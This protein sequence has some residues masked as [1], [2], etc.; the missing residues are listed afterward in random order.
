MDIK[1]LCT[2]WGYKHLPADEFL[3][4]VKSA[5][6]DGV[7]TWMPENKT[8]RK[9]FIQLIEQLDLSI[10]SH[11]HQATGNNIQAFCKSFEYYLNVALECEPLL[12]NSHSGRDFFTIDEQLAVIDV[13]ENFSAKNNITVAHETHRGRIGFCPGNAAQLF[14]LRP[15]MKITADLS[16]WVCVTESYLENFEKIVDEAINR[17]MHVH[18]RVGFIE[19]PQVPDPRLPQWQEALNH[20][21][22]WWQ[23]IIENKKANNEALIT[24][25][26]EFG[27]P[28]YMWTGLADNEPLA[29]QWDINLHIKELIK[30]I[31]EEGAANKVI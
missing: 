30:T 8:E 21:K 6:Y 7:D 2:Q 22:K 31:F 23:N 20:F 29:N 9:N 1:I 12:I 5:G 3:E 13:A 19:G 18:A 15:S 17:T 14:K 4:K 10:V 25:T 27:P 11:Q 16:H 26:P 24:F 28:P